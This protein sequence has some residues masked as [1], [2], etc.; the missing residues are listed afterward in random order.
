MSFHG[1]S[2]SYAAKV[3][4]QIYTWYEQPPLVPQLCHIVRLC[5]PQPGTWYWFCSAQER[6]IIVFPLNKWYSCCSSLKWM[7]EHPSWCHTKPVVRAV[8]ASY[9]TQLYLCWTKSSTSQ[10]ISFLT[11]T[12]SFFFSVSANHIAEARVPKKIELN[13]REQHTCYRCTRRNECWSL[14]CHKKAF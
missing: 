10:L 1:K 8:E 13:R 5:S 11:F 2:I 3:C 9:Q 14:L 12:I 4:F 7:Y 6:D